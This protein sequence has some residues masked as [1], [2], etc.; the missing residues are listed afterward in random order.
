[1][2]MS[3][4]RTTTLPR[5]GT[6]GRKPVAIAVAAAAISVMAVM[7]YPYNQADD[8]GPRAILVASALAIAVTAILFG[9]VASRAAAD[10]ARAAHTALVVAGVA[11]LSVPLFFTGLPLVVGPAAAYL[12]REARNT[13]VTDGQRRRGTAAIVVGALCWAVGAAAAL[14]Y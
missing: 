1:M 14:F 9:P 8:G 6:R 11:M 13:A 7:F 10:P 5:P 4:S 2:A 12:G 3:H